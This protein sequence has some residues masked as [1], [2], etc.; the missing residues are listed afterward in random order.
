MTDR[1]KRLS[2]VS[3]A[4]WNDQ[5]RDFATVTVADNGTYTLAI[6]KGAEAGRTYL[7]LSRISLVN[8]ELQLSWV[9]S[10]G[11]VLARQATS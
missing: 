6:H 2:A 1:H 8:D 10:D 3:V 9:I 7:N 11:L 4:T 5:L